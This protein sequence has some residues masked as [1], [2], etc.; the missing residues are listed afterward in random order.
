MKK[1]SIIFIVLITL[2]VPFFAVRAAEDTVEQ[3]QSRINT[4][5]DRIKY[6]RGLLGEDVNGDLSDPLGADDPPADQLISQTDEVINLKFNLSRGKTDNSTDGEVSILQEYLTS[7]DFYGFPITGKFDNE[8][9]LSVI[10]FQDEYAKYL[11][12]KKG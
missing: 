2:S 1:L 8:T 10:D 9:Y 12:I 7:E 4:I 3:I 5:V 11:G 6:L